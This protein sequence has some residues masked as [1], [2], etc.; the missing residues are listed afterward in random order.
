MGGEEYTHRPAT[1]NC[2]LR[3]N[4]SAERFELDGARQCKRIL[5]C[6]SVKH[7]RPRAVPKI[8][9]KVFAVTDAA[10]APPCLARLPFALEDTHDD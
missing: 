1:N 9:N 4:E 5:R 2:V 8:S 6:G 10:C 7:A 3:R